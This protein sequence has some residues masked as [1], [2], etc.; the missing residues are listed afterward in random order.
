MNLLVKL[1]KTLLW[2]VLAAAVC[3]AL[4]AL[5]WWMGWPLVT[6]A[7]ILLGVLALVLLIG[8]CKALLHWRDKRSFVHSVL[9]EQRS[10]EGVTIGKDTS[11]VAQAW[12]DGMMVFDG[13]P[14]R[15]SLNPRYGQ[16]WFLTLDDAGEAAEEV[17]GTG[18]IGIATSGASRLFSEFARQTP[19]HKPGTGEI[20]PLIWNFMPAAVMLQVTESSTNTEN[21]PWESTLVLLA[22][23]ARKMAM[24]GIVVLIS[25][26]DLRQL[27][28]DALRAKGQRLR[29]RLQQVMLTLSRRYPVYVCVQDMECLPGMGDLSARLPVQITDCPLGSLLNESLTPAQAGTQAIAAACF[30]LRTAIDDAAAK[31]IRPQGDELLALEELGA[32]TAP[33]HT[34]LEQAFRTMPHQVSPLLR[35]VFFCQTEAGRPPETFFFDTKNTEGDRGRVLGTGGTSS[36]SAEERP[37]YVAELFS[38]TIPDDPVVV[39]PLHS[40]FSLYSS[41]KAACMTAWLVALFFVCGMYGVNVVYQYH[42]LTTH[43]YSH[44]HE[45]VT[46]N[47]TVNV[48]YRQM[49][50][51]IYLEKATRNWPLPFMGQNVLGM[52]QEQLKQRFL[53]TSY[54]DM[55]MPMLARIQGD[56]LAQDLVKND[57]KQVDLV[58][59]LSWMCDVLAARIEKGSAQGLEMAFPLTSTNEAT[60][61]PVSGEIM[62]AAINW[63]KDEAELTL[64]TAHLQHILT[65]GLTRDG[66]DVLRA[67]MQ[68]SE[69]LV[70]GSKVCLSHYWPNLANSPDDMCVPGRYTRAGYTHLINTI[71]DI[72]IVTGNSPELKQ[73]ITRYGSA[74]NREYWTAWHDFVSKFNTMWV[75]R[76]NGEDFTAYGELKSIADLPHVQALQRLA[77]ELAPLREHESAPPTW[78]DSVALLDT[79]VDVAI[80]SDKGAQHSVWDVVLTLVQSSSATLKALRDNTRDTTHLRHTLQSIPQM[81]LYLDGVLE[82]LHQ[83][84]KPAQALSLAGLHFDNSDVSTS[85]FTENAKLLEAALLPVAGN[86]ANPA[87]ALMIGL[88]DFTRQAVIVQAARELQHQWE[89]EVLSSPANLYRPT[90]IAA[91]FGEAGVVTTFMNTR[92]KPF[93]T[94]DGMDFVPARWQR[95]PFPLTTDF[96]GTISRGEAV[97]AAPAKTAYTVLVRSQPTLVNIEARE[98]PDL[99]SVT[100]QCTGKSTQLV[101]RN[102]PHDQSFDYDVEAC[103]E[104]VL[105]VDFPTVKL[106]R[107]YANFAEFLEE[108]QY[109]ERKYG[110]DDFPESADKLASLLVNEITV[111]L[112]P[113][114]VADI[115]SRKNNSMPKLQD[116]ITYVW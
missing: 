58:R 15:G 43:S 98:R 77:Q 34:V 4:T 72:R 1:L 71:E 92:L 23:N 41:T 107:T 39:K 36:F 25:A 21:T 59:Q 27:P 89:V 53:H 94:R 88:M 66:G 2:L 48:L 85:P 83:S 110:R 18:T 100:L 28:P 29:Q 63:T 104:T 37:R 76:L 19:T 50:E 62:L 96:L 84:T 114:N 78:V 90:D 49:D 12:R 54:K 5:A 75:N 109:G 93:V 112:L 91:M 22:S 40:R 60:W 73:V 35:G 81:R 64:L 86:D 87:R 14:L 65:R 42:V 103:A 101:N 24:R 38:H 111:R 8:V 116:R 70:S 56:L 67:L 44:F 95:T 115:L 3:A 102:Y 61:T 82:I 106:Q 105:R 7:V 45:E 9:Q 30:W 33:M 26:K 80:V 51:I 46:H 16:P 57:T 108:F 20:Q 6:G 32:L 97:A 113:D 10:R 69:P 11:A 17:A 47:A 52:V 79:L 99:T 13:S 31:D 68:S 74:F 55:L